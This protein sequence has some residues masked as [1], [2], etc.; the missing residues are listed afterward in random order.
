MTSA[1]AAARERGTDPLISIVSP[2]LSEREHV[3]RR[4]IGQTNKLI[5][6]ENSR[7][8]QV[9]RQAVMDELLQTVY[10][11]MRHALGAAGAEWLATELW[12]V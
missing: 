9:L 5:S 10:L 11:L 7:G 4:P 3:C 6:V 2:H 1:H 8:V 12:S